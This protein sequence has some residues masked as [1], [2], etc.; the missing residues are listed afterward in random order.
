MLIVESPVST[1]LS[2]QHTCVHIQLRFL[3]KNN[4]C[5]INCLVYNQT[6]LVGRSKNV[7]RLF[8][9]SLSTSVCVPPLFIL[10]DT[11]FGAFHWLLNKTICFHCSPVFTGCTLYCTNNI[12]YYQQFRTKKQQG[13][14]RIWGHLKNIFN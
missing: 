6:I 5:W 11:S 2:N 9:I 12:K 14:C 13:K 1:P 7:F 3:I 10:T 8:K 4:S